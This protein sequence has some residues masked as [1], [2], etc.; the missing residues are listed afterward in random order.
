[1]HVNCLCPDTDSRVFWGS[2]VISSHKGA[3]MDLSEFLGTQMAA[4]IYFCLRRPGPLNS[5]L[6]ASPA[7]EYHPAY[8]PALKTRKLS[9]FRKKLIKIFS[10]AILGIRPSISSLLSN[11]VTKFLKNIRLD[12]RYLAEV[13]NF[14][15]ATDGSNL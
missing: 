15:G 8:A 9:H 7:S 14:K 13:E 11:S 12:D 3:K 6:T 2:F 4:K 10:L 5:A 1:M